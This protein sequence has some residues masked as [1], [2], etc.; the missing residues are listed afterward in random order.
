MSIKRIT[1]GVP[2]ALNKKVMALVI[3]PMLVVMSGSL[4]FSSFSGTIDTQVYSAAG[5]LSY[6]Q[7]L[8]L[9]GYNA[10]STEIVIS[11][12]GPNQ[13]TE[14]LGNGHSPVLPLLLGTESSDSS[15]LSQ[16]IL[17]TNL[18]PG[19]YVVIAVNLK[20]TGSVGITLGGYPTVTSQSTSGPIATVE[21]DPSIIED[22]ADMEKLTGFVYGFIGINSVT[23][24]VPVIDEGETWEYDLILGLGGM[25]G[26][27]YQGQN[28]QFT[29]ATTVESAPDGSQQP[30]VTNPPVIS[31]IPTTIDVGQSI[32]AIVDS[33]VGT[34]PLSYQWTIY[35]QGIPASA[36]DF[37]EIGGTVLFHQPGDYEVSVTVS[38]STGVSYSTDSSIT[39]NMEPKVSVQPQ[40]YAIDS[41]QPYK[42]LASTVEYGT[43]SV[44]SPFKWAWYSEN[45]KIDGA[46]GSGNSATYM[47]SGP[48]KYYVSFTD[49]VRTQ[50]SSEIVDVVVNP[51]LEIVQEPLSY[52]IDQAQKYIQLSSTSRNGTLPISWQ[53]YDTAGPIAGASGEGSTA[54]LM[55]QS[56]GVYYVTFSDYAGETVQSTIATVSINHDLV[57]SADPETIDSGMTATLIATASG[58]SGGYEYSWYYYSNGAST[59]PTLQNSSSDSYTTTQLY[60]TTYFFVRVVDSDKEAADTIVE[61]IVNP[62]ISSVEFPKEVG[63]GEKLIPV[64]SGGTDPYSYKWV[65]GSSSYT[66][67][68]ISFNTQGLF[69]VSLTVTDACGE[70]ISELNSQVTVSSSDPIIVKVTPSSEKI[71]IDAN[72]LLYFI[73]TFYSRSGS[74]YE[75]YWTAV[76][77]NSLPPSPGY[78]SPAVNNSTF[79]YQ[80]PTTGSYIV[81]LF[82]ED[83]SGNFGFGTA[84]VTVNE[85][86]S[87]LIPSQISVPGE[88]PTTG[89][90]DANQGEQMTFEDIWDGGNAPFQFIW[91]VIP[92]SAYPFENPTEENWHEYWEAENT[93]NQFN[94]QP[95]IYKFSIPGTYY[96]YVFIMDANGNIQTD[97]V[98]VIVEQ[99]S[100]PGGGG[101]YQNPRTY[102]VT[103]NETGLPELATW[104]VNITGEEQ[105]GA[106]VT[107]YCSFTLENGSYEFTV[108]TDYEDTIK[109]IEYN[110]YPASGIIEVNG[111]NVSIEVKFSCDASLLTFLESGL[112]HGIT[113]YLN[114]T[115]GQSFRSN[116]S[117]IQIIEG[118]GIYNYSVAS[119]SPEYRSSE[120]NASFTVDGANLSISIKFEIVTY[121]VDFE[122]TGLPI[123]I[124]W[125][126][127]VSDG[128]EY[129]TSS[130]SVTMMLPNG[131]YY[132]NVSQ[133]SLYHSSPDKGMITV[134]GSNESFAITFTEVT[135][136][137]TFIESGLQKN[138]AW[139]VALG[140]QIQYS[141]RS[142]ITYNLPNGSY[143]FEVSPVK[144]Y[145][146]GT[147]EIA[148]E[149][150]GLNVTD[151]ISFSKL[152]PVTFYE[153]GL[154]SGTKW[155]VSFDGNTTTSLNSTIK[156][157]AVNGS[158]QF[159]VLKISNYTSEPSS[160]V[161]TTKGVSL[162]ETVV[163]T[164]TKGFLSGTVTPKNASIYVGGYKYAAVNGNFN[165]SLNPGT[166]Q[167][168]ICIQGYVAFTTD[169][170]IKSASTLSLGNQNLTKIEQPD[171]KK[172]PFLFILTIVLVLMAIFIA[173]FMLTRRKQ[174]Y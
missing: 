70:S 109:N 82:V 168:T 57:V 50:V 174:Q 6:S 83:A 36:T 11:G 113:W 173:F 56:P 33:K 16:D 28:C 152:Y 134:N 35:V 52:S 146:S 47:P 93:T 104:Y 157:Y 71:S 76:P 119:S 164:L 24:T 144:G 67:S 136:E 105:S 88:A 127:N 95:F 3:V 19:D 78:Y 32:S 130:T 140:G 55:P 7:S 158:Y 25:S 132:Y 139:S 30:V 155:G 54:L 145:I 147:N 4:A 90:I 1:I 128:M 92:N 108:F 2:A 75:D 41:G 74:S 131:T 9:Q 160:G 60:T 79:S 106:I 12:Q 135:Y 167:V 97:P 69:I 63:I 64:V 141:N 124:A 110:A 18:A 153:T 103:F 5:T 142:Y 29:I 96:V 17:I 121:R 99:Q 27:T 80:F 98:E 170:T 112:P 20:D 43:S 59:G 77:S 34:S 45:G 150:G 91:I 161:V 118:P 165:I 149:V 22:K 46:D 61:V 86:D 85:I 48:G 51:P 23:Q 89:P 122:E 115:D 137:V 40:S 15:F 102:T 162:S 84:M 14:V 138:T 159:T 111:K 13:N 114:L 163:F 81:Y 154:P 169:V 49:S 123:G 58:G 72:Q 117:G 42:L 66:N 94:S 100:G 38:G 37:S 120:P 53:W 39:V 148:L 73:G 133:G 31:I 125:S 26:N 116:S 143:D 129:S 126:L 21:C 156:F 8:Q 10:E 172:E 65:V 171:S 101:N 68:T 44:S 62:G 166:Y 151:P 107:N 87:P